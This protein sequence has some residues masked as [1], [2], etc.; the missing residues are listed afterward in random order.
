MTDPRTPAEALRWADDD[1]L[2]GSITDAVCVAAS[3]T[4]R[5]DVAHVGQSLALELKLRGFAIVR[6]RR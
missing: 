4:H 5:R 3:I 6:V 2:D 1:D